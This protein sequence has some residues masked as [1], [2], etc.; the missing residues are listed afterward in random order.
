MA[1]KILTKDKFPDD[2]EA[3]FLEISFR[4]CKWLLCGLYQPPSQTDQ[5]FFQ[6]ILDL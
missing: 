1:C 2:T 5:Y 3:L 4:K 6:N